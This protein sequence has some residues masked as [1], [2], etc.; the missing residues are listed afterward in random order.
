MTTSILHKEKP[1]RSLAE[2]E[3]L[4]DS[5]EKTAR[6]GKGSF[7]NVRLAREKKSGKLFAMKMVPINLL[8]SITMFR[9]IF[10]QRRLQSRQLQIFKQ[11]FKSINNLITLISL[12]SMVISRKVSMLIWFSIMLKVALYIIIYTRRKCLLQMKFSISSTKHV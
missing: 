3:F 10:T 12:N 4:Q 8:E 1:T 9:S 11:K 5:K 6:L 7:A 2:F